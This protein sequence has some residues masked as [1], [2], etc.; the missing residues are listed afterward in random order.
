MGRMSSGS[1][2]AQR[3]DVSRAVF[4]QIVQRSDSVMLKHFGQLW[5]LWSPWSA[6]AKSSAFCVSDLYSESTRRSASF[7]PMPGRPL[8]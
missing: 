4:V 2:R 7:G 6:V 3:R 5:T 8:K 1:S